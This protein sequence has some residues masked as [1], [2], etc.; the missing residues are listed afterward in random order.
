MKHFWLKTER[1]RSILL[2]TL[3]LLALWEAGVRL[4]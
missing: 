3:V 4:S 1:G 2:T